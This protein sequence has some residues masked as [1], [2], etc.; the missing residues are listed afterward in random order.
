MI[1]KCVNAETVTWQATSRFKPKSYRL[2][3]PRLAK[4]IPGTG[5]LTV[6]PRKFEKIC[7]SANILEFIK[8]EALSNLIFNLR[9]FAYSAVLEQ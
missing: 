3:F 4:Y 9:F 2:L 5:M 8:I 7:G 1:A 6:F